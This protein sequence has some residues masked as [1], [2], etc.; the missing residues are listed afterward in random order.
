MSPPDAPTPLVIAFG[1]PRYSSAHGDAPLP[2]VVPS[3]RQ[4]S[5]AP[6]TPS[7]E[8]AN[9]LPA[10]DTWIAGSPA[11][12]APQPLLPTVCD[13]SWPATNIAGA[14]ATATPRRARAAL[15]DVDPHPEVQ[16]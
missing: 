7:S 16:P 6:P 12:F 11:V 8:P 2:L 10:R 4:N 15:A 3:S 9:R 5:L 13:C 1:W 14:P